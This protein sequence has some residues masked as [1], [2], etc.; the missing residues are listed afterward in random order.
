MKQRILIYL[1]SAF[2][3]FTACE[4]KEA[5]TQ[6]SE[7]TNVV[8]NDTLTIPNSTEGLK[9]S[10]RLTPKA[11]T[12]VKNWQLYQGLLKRLDSLQGVSLG[13]TKNQLAILISTFDGQE[14]AEEEIVNL[15]PDNLETPAIK[16]RL[17]SVETK[18][19]IVNNY[20][21]KSEPNVEE[22]TTGVIALKNAFQNLNLQINENFALTIEEMLE[23]LN[24]EVNNP[25]DSPALE[26]S[27]PTGKPPIKIYK[28]NQ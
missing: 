10:L 8:T 28:P 16:A 12:A 27:N 2:F 14:E 20:A 9:P 3:L 23:Q 13:K 24:Q 15:T 26:N 4:K 11:Q 21:Q 18:L 7:T 6:A 25:E 5:Q 19:K 17:L 22:I 1:L